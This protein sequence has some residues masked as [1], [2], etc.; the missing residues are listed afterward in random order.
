[1]DNKNIFVLYYYNL[2]KVNK[3]KKVR[4]VYALK[5]RKGEKGL[6]NSLGGKF[7]VQSCFILPVK[8]DQ[9]MKEI[10]KLWDVP[11]KRKKIVLID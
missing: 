7:L 3:S 5:G 4:F 11:F 8:K 2:S 9:E 6:V 1:M 10:F